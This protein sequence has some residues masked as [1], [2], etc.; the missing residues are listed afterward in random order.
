[1]AADVDL[2]TLSETC[3]NFTGADLKAVLYN[4]QLEAIHETMDVAAPGML[5]RVIKSA[6]ISDEDNDRVSFSIAT[7][8]AQQP[9]QQTV[10]MEMC[11]AHI[12]ALQDGPVTPS[13]VT[14]ERLQKEV[15]SH[16]AQ[17]SENLTNRPARKQNVSMV[18]EIQQK[19]LLKAAGE[20]VPSVQPAERA[21]YSQIYDAFIAG[22]GG[23]FR[24]DV[25]SAGKRATLA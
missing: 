12:P 24:H 25:T 3:V 7:T 1:M 23:N 9:L 10:A 8:T 18:I 2:S 4:A 19:H 15:Q 21:K 6:D 17:W 11:C 13:G 5:G 20:M 14:I 16:T 22:K